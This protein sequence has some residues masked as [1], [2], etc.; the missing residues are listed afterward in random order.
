MQCRADTRQRRY[1]HRC[2]NYLQRGRSTEFTPGVAEAGSTHYG[3]RHDTHCTRRP[4]VD[5]STRCHDTKGSEAVQHEA[6]R[7]EGIADMQHQDEAVAECPLSR[8]S[9]KTRKVEG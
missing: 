2:I 9:A 4:G 7:D 8:P 1:D 3:Q 6:D 5:A